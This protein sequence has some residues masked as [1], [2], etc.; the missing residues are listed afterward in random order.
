MGAIAKT[1]QP[2]YYAVI[3]T[4]IRSEGDNGYEKMANEMV[5]TGFRQPGFLGAE[6][7]RD[8]GGIGITV[9]YWESLEAI[10]N[11][12]NHARH[13]EA[14]K[15]GQDLWYESFATRVCKVEKLGLFMDS[16]HN[17]RGK[18]EEGQV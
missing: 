17:C 16:G 3:F 14:Q 13:R 10:E 7:V 11:W 6:S 4:S 1:L 15:L 5:E 12:K 18:S 8:A 9:S 2:P